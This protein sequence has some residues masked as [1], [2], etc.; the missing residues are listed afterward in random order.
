MSDNRH[1]TSNILDW[2]PTFRVLNMVVQKGVETISSDEDITING[3][4]SE[5]SEAFRVTRKIFDEFYGASIQNKS[6]PIILML[7]NRSDVIRYHIESAKRYSPLLSYFDS[8]GYK[9]I[10]LMDAFGNAD[11]RDLFSGHYSPLANKLVAKYILGYINN[12]SNQEN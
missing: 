2:S 10:D 3:R 4:Y 9:Y 12:V 7:P 11:V 6:V 8:T 1:Y 5:K